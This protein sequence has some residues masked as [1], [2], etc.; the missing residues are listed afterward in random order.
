[1]PIIPALNREAFGDVSCLAKFARKPI[2]QGADLFSAQEE[3]NCCLPFEFGA[4]DFSGDSVTS[5]VAGGKCLGTTQRRPIVS[6]RRSCD[7]YCAVPVKLNQARAYIMEPLERGEANDPVRP[8]DDDVVNR[9]ISSAEA[10]VCRSTIGAVDNAE[11][12]V[13][14]GNA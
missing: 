6:G 8:G 1:M 14:Y 2:D 4:E 7:K 5:F 11:V 13:V 12:A 9:A 10:K 3:G